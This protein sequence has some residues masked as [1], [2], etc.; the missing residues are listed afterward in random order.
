ME[1]EQSLFIKCKSSQFL[2]PSFF[3]GGLF[4][5]FGRFRSILSDEAFFPFSLSVPMS[6]AIM[7]VVDL[8]DPC[9]FVF[10]GATFMGTRANNS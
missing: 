7:L 6:F 3:L 1:S 5:L 4:L 2:S 8:L 10:F 9:S